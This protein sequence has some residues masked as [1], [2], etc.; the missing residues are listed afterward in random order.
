M[1]L[2]NNLELSKANKVESEQQKP[3]STQFPIYVICVMLGSLSG[4][5]G[6]A[7]AIGFAIIFELYF[8][9]TL[10]SGIIPLTLIAVTAGLGIAWS[11]SRFGARLFHTS[12]TVKELEVMFVASVLTGLLQVFTYMQGF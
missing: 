11:S 8:F 2:L 3:F 9:T 7:L 5:L 6:V 1:S 12:Y 10:L 4:A